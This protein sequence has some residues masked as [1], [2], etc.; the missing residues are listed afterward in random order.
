M[1][2]SS[3]ICYMYFVNKLKSPVFLS[4]RFSYFMEFTAKKFAGEHKRTIIEFAMGKINDAIRQ[5]IQKIH[6]GTRNLIL[7]SGQ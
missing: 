1:P 7:V 5:A 6:T 4:T 3:I 2:V